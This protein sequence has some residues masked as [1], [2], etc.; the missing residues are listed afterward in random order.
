MHTKNI[1]PLNEVQKFS[2]AWWLRRKFGLSN[3][4]SHGANTKKMNFPEI[5]ISPGC[6]GRKKYQ[7][8]LWRKTHLL[9]AEPILVD[10]TFFEKIFLINPLIK[11]NRATVLEKTA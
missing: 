5:K 10:S 3:W 11:G 8:N 9:A 7:M 4:F 1:L 6:T 2:G